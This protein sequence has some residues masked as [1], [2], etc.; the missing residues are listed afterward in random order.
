MK[1]VRWIFLGVMLTIFAGTVQNGTIS[2]PSFPKTAWAQEAPGPIQ[3]TLKDEDP[4]AFEQVK[5]FYV[6]GEKDSEKKINAWLKE[7]R[8]SIRRVTASGAGSGSGSQHL[9]I[10]YTK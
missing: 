3:R 6:S 1:N 8:P 7:E 10:F 4:Q 5:I 9:Y 2:I